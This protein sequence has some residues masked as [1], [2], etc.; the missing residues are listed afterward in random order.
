MASEWLIVGLGNPGAHYAE[1]RHN[2]GARCVARLAR[3]HGIELRPRRLYSL[4][5]GEIAGRPVSL[6][7][8]RTFMNESGRAV[9][10]LLRQEGLPPERLLVICDDLDLPVGRLRLRPRNGH[11]GHNGLR[12]VIGELGTG[13][14]PRL[15]IGIG[16]PQA[17]GR[18]VTDP[19]L[20]AAYVLSL[21]PPGEREA[22]EEAIAVAA[23]ALEVVIAEGLEAAMNRYNR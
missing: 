14:F 6:A 22:L 4:G 15:R 13:G 12:S 19:D 3:R 16:R 18:P 9:A 11:G 7:R 10:A 21:P 17:E 5:Q 20:V 23:E 8:P 2:V 1:T